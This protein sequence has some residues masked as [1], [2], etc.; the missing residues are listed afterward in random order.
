[1][2][3]SDKTL[4]GS[5]ALIEQS[6][7]QSIRPCTFL[8]LPGEIRNRIYQFALVTARPFAVQLQ[9]SR[10]LDTAL[11]RVNRQI[12]DEASGIFYAENTFRFP[13]ALFVEAPILQQLQTLYRVSRSSLC[14]MRSVVLEI[15]VSRPF[16]LP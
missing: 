11:L 14:M 6:A 1:M 4:L 5:S 7:R 16:R 2:I 15:P 13:E 12:L 8:A 9:W 10:P 3:P